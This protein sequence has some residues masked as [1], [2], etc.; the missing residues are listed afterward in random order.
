MNEL[1]KE[2]INH[3]INPCSVIECI[4]YLGLCNDYNVKG[5]IK[6]VNNNNNNILLISVDYCTYSTY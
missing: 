5:E 2:L 6:V 4:L 3:S 1:D